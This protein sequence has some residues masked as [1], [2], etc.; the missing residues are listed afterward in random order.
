MLIG[1]DEIEKVCEQKWKFDLCIPR[2]PYLSRQRL[3]LALPT[4]P[5]PRQSRLLWQINVVL[6]GQRHAPHGG[7]IRQRHQRDQ[8]PPASHRDDIC[9]KRSEQSSSHNLPAAPESRCRGLHHEKYAKARQILSSSAPMC[10]VCGFVYETFHCKLQ[11]I[12]KKSWCLYACWFAAVVVCLWF[13]CLGS[14][15][16][17]VPLV[18]PL[19]CIDLC[20][21]LC[22]FVVRYSF[23]HS[24]V[25][26]VFLLNWKFVVIAKSGDGF[27]AFNHS[28]STIWQNHRFQKNTEK[29]NFWRLVFST[30]FSMRKKSKKSKKGR[31]QISRDGLVVLRRP[32]GR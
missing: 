9:S 2:A 6:S 32:P 23:A 17:L 19:I 22:K 20:M 26:F 15:L 12:F 24:S 1:R 28:G 25:K 8:S 10:N 30:F 18:P 11:A 14:L 7:V 13:C 5:S 21:S 29:V 16:V 4:P 31:P 27:F 3:L